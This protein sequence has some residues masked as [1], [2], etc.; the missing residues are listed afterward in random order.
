MPFPRVRAMASP[1]HAPAERDPNFSVLA[2]YTTL[3][4]RRTQSA[5]IPPFS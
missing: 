4:E 1:L 5:G 3:D 2:S